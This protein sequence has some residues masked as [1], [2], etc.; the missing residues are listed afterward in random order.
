MSK[1]SK[2]ESLEFGS[3]SFLDIVANVV[4]ILIILIVIAGLRVSR[5][6]IGEAPVDPPGR[7]GATSVE[8]Q[9]TP[10]LD[11]VVLGPE[12]PPVVEESE[13]VD[14][15]ALKD[16][17]MPSDLFET[18]SSGEVLDEPPLGPPEP[19]R[20]LVALADRLKSEISAAADDR[21]WQRQRLAHV[22]E[23]AASTRD[24]LPRLQQTVEQEAEALAQAKLAA[25]E[26]DEDRNRA[27]RRLQEMRSA[28]R[29]TRDQPPTTQVLNHRVT[30]V[31]RAVE[32][33][34]VHFRLAAGRVSVVPI[35]S[36]TVSLKDRIE[37]NKDMLFRLE[38]YEGTVGPLNGYLLHYTVQRQQLSVLEELRNGG[39]VL[40]IGLSYYEIEPL[41][42]A[43]TESAEEALAAGSRFREALQLAGASSTLTFWIYPDSFDL[44]Q[45]LQ[46]YAHSIGFDVAARPLP[47]GV[48]I[49]GS[50]NG[51]RSVAQ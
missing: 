14:V 40:R 36:L 6:P 9:F 39:P 33:S 45:R 48:P 19:P 5:A 15:G 4:G 30:P 16:P 47:Q 3:D 23:R 38:R 2:R 12:S 8:F 41:P 1:S 26:R 10:P 24:R 18:A 51:S 20:E 28:V 21:D 11:L 31:G 35:Q 43:P 17:A 27:E 7:S 13:L 25:V 50:P 37:R 34:E 32:G 42:G 44:H 46:E 22:R 29:L 49:A